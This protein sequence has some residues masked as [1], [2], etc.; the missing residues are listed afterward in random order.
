MYKVYQVV[1]GDTIDSIAKKYNISSDELLSLNGLS[2]SNIVPGFL[3]VVPSKNANFINYTIGKGDTLYTISTKYNVPIETILLLN[4]LNKDD[5]I[6]PGETLLLPK[7]GIGVYFTI[8][9][10]SL[11]EIVKYS[12]L[13]DIVTMNDQIYLRPNQVIIY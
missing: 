6:Y 4:G 11:R 7:E 12:N 2:D 13:N 10:D 1:N 3:L 5:Y 9:G 8:D